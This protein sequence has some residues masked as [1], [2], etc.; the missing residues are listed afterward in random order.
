MSTSGGLLICWKQMP[1]SGHDTFEIS[2]QLKAHEIRQL[3]G[4]GCPAIK[5]ELLEY[6]PQCHAAIERNVVFEPFILVILQF[7]LHTSNHNVH[8]SFSETA[9]E[10]VPTSARLWFELSQRRGFNLSDP[11]HGAL[12]RTIRC[13]NDL[14]VDFQLIGPEACGGRNRSQLEGLY[15]RTG[16]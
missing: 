16:L 14:R 6:V 3:D 7:P 10:V 4:Q 8:E 12:G 15:L 2:A 11:S 9:L 13:R 5:L 1:L